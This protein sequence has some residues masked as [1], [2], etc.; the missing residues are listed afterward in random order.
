[1]KVQVIEKEGKPAFVVLPIEEYETLLQRLEDLEDVHDLQEYRANPGESLPAA[2]VDRLLKGKNPIKH[3]REFR[4][5]TQAELAE[6]VKVTAA[7]I[8]QIE[9]GKRECSVRLLQ[10]LS[11]A[12]AVDMALLL[13]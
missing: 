12:L 13:S 7:H 11:K 3:W 10:A 1:M 9:N 2:F 6:K 5:M 8:S 4:G